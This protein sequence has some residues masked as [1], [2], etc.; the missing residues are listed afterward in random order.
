[1]YTV[2]NSSNRPFKLLANTRRGISQKVEPLESA[3]SNRESTKCGPQPEISLPKPVFNHQANGRRTQ[4]SKNHQASENYPPHYEELIK[5]VSDSWDSVQEEYEC[6]K[7]STD[8]RVPRVVY[9]QDNSTNSH[10]ANFEPFDLE[11]FW[12][13]R[14]LQNI[15]Q[16]T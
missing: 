12:G 1:M 6:S 9:Y 11:S 10:L 15:Q 3:S 7:Q 14:F 4:T 5:Y 8:N 13:E 2:S 16:S